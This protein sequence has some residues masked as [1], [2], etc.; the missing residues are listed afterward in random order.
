M[1]KVLMVCHGNLC[2]SPMAELVARQMA[3]QAGLGKQHSFESAGTHAGY[4][5]PPDPRARDALTKRGYALGKGKARRITDKDF[6]TADLVLAMD[7]DNM[8]ALRRMCPSEHVHKLRMFLEFAPQA[9][10]IEV[11]DP[12]YG[13]SQGFEAVLDLCE[14]GA[15]GLIA[16]LRGMP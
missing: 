4:K 3:Q 13:S 6:A 7:Q 8:N 5:E 10:T 11:P 14:A 16:Q 2:R 15:R 9:G 12:Y 1:A